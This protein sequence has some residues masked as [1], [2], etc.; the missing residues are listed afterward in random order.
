MLSEQLKISTTVEQETIG[1]ARLG[2]ARLGGA[3]MCWSRQQA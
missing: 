2:R 3:K 1:R